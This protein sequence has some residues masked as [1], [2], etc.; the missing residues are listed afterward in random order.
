M[1]CW[2]DQEGLAGQKRR[3]R[4]RRHDMDRENEKDSG[5]YL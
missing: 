3:E 2:L 1:E 5:V 4:E